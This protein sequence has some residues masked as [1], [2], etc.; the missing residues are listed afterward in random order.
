MSKLTR[1]RL[2]GSALATAAG[3]WPLLGRAQPLE[4]PAAVTRPD[5]FLPPPNAQAPGSA[6][7]GS[8]ALQAGMRFVWFGASASIPGERSQIVPD[9]D[10]NWINQRTGQ[11]YRQF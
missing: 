8:G 7:A 5:L 9:P 6:P 11:R 3:A 10:G 1:R 2:V 4:L